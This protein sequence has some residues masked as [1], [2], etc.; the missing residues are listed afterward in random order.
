MDAWYGNIYYSKA[1]VKICGSESKQY[2][3]FSP[4]KM[5]I[6][7]PDSCGLLWCFYQL[8]ELSFWR[9]PFTAEDPLVSFSKSVLMKKQ[10]HLDGLRL[11]K[12]SANLNYSFK[13]V[14][15]TLWRPFLYNKYFNNM[16]IAFRHDTSKINNDKSVSNQTV[17][18]SLLWENHM[19][20]AAPLRKPY[21]YS[22]TLTFTTKVFLWCVQLD[23]GL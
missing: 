2:H 20:K 19:Q 17:P 23:T 3:L 21:I 9:H 6:D 12:C 5:F 16:L 11:S 15:N 13:V 14:R 10:T 1:W 22:G 4:N 7:W 18:A 8:F